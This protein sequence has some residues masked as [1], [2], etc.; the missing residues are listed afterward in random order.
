MWKIDEGPDEEEKPQI[1][2]KI[3]IAIQIVGDVQSFHPRVCWHSHMQVSSTYNH[4][5]SYWKT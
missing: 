1:S 5:M 4:Y 3:I 2:E